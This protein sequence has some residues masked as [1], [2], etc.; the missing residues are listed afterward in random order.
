MADL[1]Q[2]VF[3]NAQ[4]TVI[5]CANHSSTFKE[6]AWLPLRPVRGQITTLPATATSSALQ[7]VVCDEGYL[8][9]AINN[10]HCIG[11]SFVPGDTSTALRN[12]E[13]QH[14]LQLLA[15]IAP[16]LLEEWKDTGLHGRAALRCTTPDHLPMIGQ[17][18]DREAFLRD[19]ATLRHNARA[20]ITTPGTYI[21]GLWVLAGFGGRGL[22]YIPLA[23]ELLASQLLQQPAPLPHTLQM[24]LA[25]GRFV[26]RELIRANS[27]PRV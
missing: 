25:P 26:I 14:N 13:Q 5:A 11:A 8:T 24:A 17:V 2:P 15:D 18:P 7:C 19:Y 21:E 9:P 10:Q 16:H 27:Q 1:Q 3:T 6:T 12:N 20:T 4:Q 23:A 22:C